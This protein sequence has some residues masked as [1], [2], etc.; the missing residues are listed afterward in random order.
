MNRKWRRG[1]VICYIALILTA[2]GTYAAWYILTAS[3]SMEITTG[4]ADLSITVSDLTGINEGTPAN[5]ASTFT[6]ND[7]VLEITDMLTSGEC[8]YSVMLTADPANTETL[9]LVGGS[10]PIDWSAWEALGFSAVY[11][12]DP[13]TRSWAPGETKELAFHIGIADDTVVQPSTNYPLI[14]LSFA[15]EVSPP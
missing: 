2:V 5:C 11:T 15:F 13:A 14:V 8:L 12:N 6:G 9:V 7:V 1:F 3:V 10:N 4:G